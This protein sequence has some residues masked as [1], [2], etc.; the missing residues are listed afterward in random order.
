[1]DFTS[2]IKLKKLKENVTISPSLWIIYICLHILL[3]HSSFCGW[4]MVA[5][6]KICLFVPTYVF[7]LTG[8]WDTS[9]V[10]FFTSVT[11][12]FFCIGSFTSEYKNALNS[13][14]KKKKANPSLIL[15]FFRM[16]LLNICKELSTHRPSTYLAPTISWTHYHQNFMPTK[17]IA[18]FCV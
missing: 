17:A 7:F 8:H 13:H 15:I 3:L 16:L 14:L 4:N 9:Q 11:S 6:K 10:S 12:V 2:Q 5:S 1:M 18:H